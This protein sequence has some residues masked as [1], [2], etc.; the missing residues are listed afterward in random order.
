MRVR[1][2]LWLAAVA[3]V[4]M[5]A[6]TA[7]AAPD[8][9]AGAIGTGPPS[10]YDCNRIDSC[11]LGF[12]PNGEAY[13]GI[14]ADQ[15]PLLWITDFDH[16]MIILK[17]TLACTMTAIASFPAPGGMAPSE[18]AF[19]GTFLYHYDF[20]TGL[21]YTIDPTTGMVVGSC[22]PPGDDLAEGLTWREGFLWKGDSQNIYVFT[23]PPDC[24]V[25]NSFPN[26]GGDSADGL[27]DCGDYIIM[28]GYSGVIY[29]LDPSN[30]L[31]VEQ[32]DLNEGAMGNGLAS[33][34]LGVLWADHTG[35]YVDVVAVNCYV[36]FPV[37]ETSWGTIK[38]MYAQ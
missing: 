15:S 17:P 24:T 33:D 12:L 22:N 3:V 26:P 28:L 37:E 13:G 5:M 10:D 1:N 19:D 36:P 21:L 4:V 34:G 6:G 7:L 16:N 38:A 2:H 35:G 8:D 32:C 14:L 30:G 23:P 31:I 20:G 11:E 25:V 9:P 29:Q 27:A 18:N